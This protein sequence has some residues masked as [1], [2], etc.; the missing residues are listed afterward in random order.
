MHPLRTLTRPSARPW[1]LAT[2]AA[3][4]SLALLTTVLLTRDG[5]G[6]TVSTSAS[7]PG[8]S[9]AGPDHGRVAGAVELDEAP[10]ALTTVDATGGVDQLDLLDGSTRRLADLGPVRALAT[11]GRYVFVR[12]AGGLEVVD[13]GVWTWDHVDHVHYYRAQARRVGSL[14]GTGPATVTTTGS[15]VSGGTGVLFTDSGEAVLLD[16]AALGDGEVRERYRLDVEPH[17]GLLVPIGEQALLTDPGPD[18]RPARVLVLDADGDPVPGEAHR[19]RA[20]AGSITTRVGAVVGCADGALLATSTETGV[21]VERIAYPRGT[22]APPATGFA[23]RE[24]RPTVAGLAGG[25]RVWLLDTRER[26]W[27]LLESPVPLQQVAAVDDDDEHVLGVTTRGRVTVLDGRTGEL[28]ASTKPLA[29]R[30]TA[31]GTTVPPLVV[32]QQRAY[33]AAPVEQRL[34][35]IDF[36]DDARVARTF[37]TTTE[38]LLLAGTGR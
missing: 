29:A 17:D 14:P 28:L 9:D 19:C 31:A 7:P 25:D 26:T 20:A 15:S 11:D 8:N 23:G 22:T 12:T 24:G 1:A 6:S 36:A 27:R 38:P 30:S 18:G 2:V 10:L 21:D 37:E 35:E 16:T 13:S 33:L 4:A 5:P 3:V 34:H 32:D